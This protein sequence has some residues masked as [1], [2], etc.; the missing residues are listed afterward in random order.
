MESLR[1]DAETLLWDP[2]LPECDA[3]T[4]AAFIES[5]REASAANIGLLCEHDRDPYYCKE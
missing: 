2:I 5:L 1:S 3:S 4:A